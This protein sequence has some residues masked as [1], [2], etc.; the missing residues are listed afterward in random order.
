[1]SKEIIDSCKEKMD[2]SIEA[3]KRDLNSIRAGKANPQVLDRITVEYYGSNAPINQVGNISSPEPRMLVI[4]PYDPTTIP[5]IEKAILASDLGLTPANDGKVIRLTFPEL[6]EE[7]RKEIA[8][9][10]KARGEEAKVAIRSI[11]RDKN[12]ALKKEKKDGLLTEDQLA[13]DEE[14]IQ[15]VTDKAIKDVDAVLAEKEKEILNV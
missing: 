13:D 8:K 7:R 9:Q 6:T 4:S 5:E 12:E 15:K 14:S 3:L 10:V 1:M 2:K 11:R